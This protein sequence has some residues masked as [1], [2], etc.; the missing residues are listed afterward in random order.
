MANTLPPGFDPA[1]GR[2]N[3]V[4]PPGFDP[5]TGRLNLGNLSSFAGS[6]TRTTTT[7]YPSSRTSSSRRSRGLWGRFNDFISGIGDWIGD[8]VEKL[9]EWTTYIVMGAALIGLLIYVISGFCDSFW[10]GV[11]HTVLAIIGGVIAYIGTIVIAYIVAILVFAL[12]FCFYNATIFL[13]IVFGLG[14]WMG[15]NWMKHANDEPTVIETV[16]NPTTRYRVT[17]RVLNIRAMPSS[18]ASVIGTYKQGDEIEVY[19][20]SEGFALVH[21]NGQEGYVSTSYIEKVETTTTN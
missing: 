10:T 1:T 2:W 19:A 17:A 16:V 8:S 5:R 9:V 13:L 15:Y 7:T 14:G 3:K 20:D 12:R 4:L 6:T 18:N 11:G 21:Y